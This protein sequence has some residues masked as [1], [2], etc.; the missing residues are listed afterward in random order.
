MSFRLRALGGVWN[1]GECSSGLVDSRR[2]VVGFGQ[3]ES[4]WWLLVT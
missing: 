3:C 1:W 4:D 2:N